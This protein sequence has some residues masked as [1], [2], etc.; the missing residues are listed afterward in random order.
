[1]NDADSFLPPSELEGDDRF[2][3]EVDL[4]AFRRGLPRLKRTST[5][6]HGVHFLNRHLSSSLSRD[7]ANG[8]ISG[9][10]FAFLKTLTYAG[11]CQHSLSAALTCTH[12]LKVRRVIDAHTALSPNGAMFHMRMLS[13]SLMYLRHVPTFP[14]CV[15]RVYIA[16]EL[17]GTNYRAHFLFGS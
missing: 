12:C 3:L 10:L 14:V 15:L 8:G 9:S 5:I 2:V 11:D 16:S 13:R 17:S 7:P 1:M 6:G 4:G